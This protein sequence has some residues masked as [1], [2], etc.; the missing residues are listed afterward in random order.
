M[1][2]NIII[3][4]FSVFLLGSLMS[5]LGR[6]GGNFYVPLLVAAGFS[7]SM[8]AA[9]AQFILMIVSLAAM[10]IFHQHRTIDWKLALMIDPPTDI[11]AFA[12][13]FYAHRFNDGCLKIVFA[14][15]L[16]IAVVFMIRP[17][18]VK[19]PKQKKQI[20]FWTRSFG[21]S[22]Y[23]VNLWLTIP[24]TA[25]VGFFAGMTGISGGS[26]KIPIMVLLCG[27]P[28][29]IAVGTSSAMVAFTAMMG[30]GGHALAGDFDSI[31]LIPFIVTAV[32]AGLLGGHISLKIKPVH[33]KRWFAYTTLATAVFMAGHALWND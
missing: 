11:M 20:G 26:F 10:C 14:L 25:G 19:K 21:G 1:T 31:W 33:L 7:M 4:C 8:A 18:R 24:L 6:G 2:L 13:G 15:L 22:Q 5:M 30:F 17:I 3:V 9:H 23:Q 12:G 29:R 16:T 32:A 28:M 27:V